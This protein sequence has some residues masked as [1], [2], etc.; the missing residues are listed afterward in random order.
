MDSSNQASHHQ[1]QPKTLQGCLGL[2]IS[3]TDLSLLPDA[4]RQ[5]Q[6][7]QQ[8]PIYTT[9]GTLWKPES[10]KPIRPPVRRGRASLGTSGLAGVDQWL[11]HSSHDGGNAVYSRPQPDIAPRYSPLQQNNDRAVSPQPWS[12]VSQGINPATILGLAPVT[13]IAALPGLRNG[14][15]ATSQR[16][17]RGQTEGEDEGV[18]GDDIHTSYQLANPVDLGIGNRPC[19][20]LDQQRAQQGLPPGQVPG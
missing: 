5:Q 15:M 2:G 4:A 1:A 19:S 8:R 14:S 6:Q 16:P 12:L 11:L 17:S 18:D 3:A 9:A 10:A 20:T 7:Q 13:G